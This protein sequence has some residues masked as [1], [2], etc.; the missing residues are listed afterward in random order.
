VC[1]SPLDPSTFGTRSPRSLDGRSYPEHLRA[2]ERFDDVL[3]PVVA[4]H[5]PATFDDL[6]IAIDDPRLLASLSRWL[7]SAEW[8]GLIQRLDAAARAPRTYGLGP[9][10]PAQ[11]HHAA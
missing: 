7:T 9:Q 6:S 1:V 5:E 11:L 3:L 10:A 2:Y 4:S 8:R